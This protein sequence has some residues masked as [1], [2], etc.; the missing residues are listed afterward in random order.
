MKN[1]YRKLRPY[2]GYEKKDGEELKEAIN[3]IKSYEL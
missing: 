2:R 3:L 1:T